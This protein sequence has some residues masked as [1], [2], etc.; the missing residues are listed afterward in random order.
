MSGF[1]DPKE[2]IIDT[3]LTEEGRRQLSTGK[4][5][6]NFA[7]F[8]DSTVVYSKLDQFD[9]GSFMDLHTKRINFEAKSRPQDTLIFN[10]DSNGKL[11]I[12]SFLKLSGSNDIFKVSNGKILFSSMSNFI[13]ASRE[14]L[15]N[16][17]RQILSTS[18][19]NFKDLRL[20][21][22]PKFNN[23]NINF[24]LSTNS[25]EFDITRK[26]PINVENEIFESNINQ[27]ESFFL[28]K[29]L[30][31]LPNYKFLPPINKKTNEEQIKPLG[32]YPNLGKQG[33][34]SAAELNKE[35]NVLK[36]RGAYS[37]IEF[38]NSS[39]LNT[40]LGQIFEINGSDISKLDLI[41]FGEQVFK[42]ENTLVTRHIY[43]AG[44][45]FLDDNNSHTFVNI[46]TLVFI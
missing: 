5:S 25:I 36:E 7:S 44:K 6:I 3:S 29:R 43:F 2:R 27:A 9:S 17:S 38:S 1:L 20:L 21:S 39:T 40:I 26:S 45:I 22:S 33:S 31:N 14:N 32:I 12:P 35:L 42:Q 4:I 16:Y 15:E 10:V 37:R 41:D 18:F 8:S 46:F 28:D 30:S 11:N 19:Q 34:L 24:K 13:S 23:E